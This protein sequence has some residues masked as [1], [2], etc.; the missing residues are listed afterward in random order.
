V[1]VPLGWLAEW[2]DL[3]PLE[4]F[5]ER[6]SLGALEIK[7][8]V[9]T[10]PDLSGLRVGLVCERRAHPDADRL[11]VCRVELGE[12]DPLEVVC[13][14]PNVAAGQ[15]VAL[16][17]HGATLP[18]GTR[19]KRSKI[20]GVVSAGMIC[21]A[22]ELGLGDDHAGIVVLPETAP[23]GAPLGAV[24][25]AGETILDVELI[26]NRGDCVSI[27]GLAREARALFGGDL[28]WPP[29]EPEE[30]SRAAAEDVR[31]AIDDAAG[32]PRYVARVVRDLRVGPSP[33]WLAG[34]LEAAGLRPVNNVVDVTNFVMLELG[35]P[36]HAFDL[37]K[38]HGGVIRV[39]AAADGEKLRTLDGALRALEPHDLV[40]ADASGAVAVAGVMGGAESEVDGGTRHV[41]LESAHF[42]PV[43]VRR[44]ARRLG[45]H[46]DAS[47]RFE[48]GV[49]PQG[50]RRAADRA[51]RL[52]GELAGGVV[53]RGAVEA[54]GDAAPP[55]APIALE[56]A[57]VNR[58]LGTHLT[59]DAVAALLA[60]LEIEVAPAGPGAFTCTP[61][62][63]RSDLAIPADLVEEV[64]RLHGYDRIPADLPTGPFEGASEPPERA[65]G[66]AL[67]SA[68]A[69]A[70]LVEVMTFPGVPPGDADA[71]GLAPGDPRR[72]ALAIENPV[73]AGDAVLRTSLVPSLLRVAAANLSRQVERVRIFEVGR[74]FLAREPGALPEERLAGAGLLC[75]AGGVGLWEPRDVPLFHRAKG[76]AERLLRALGREAAFQPDAGEP[77]LHPGASG[78]FRIGGHPV[79]AVGELHPDAA[80]RFGLGV[81]CALVVVDGSAL[82]A[83]PARVPRYREP[84]RHPRVRRDL[85]LLLDHRARA[86]D[87]LAAIRE[88]AGATLVAAE[89]FDR[90][91]GAGVPE[92]KVSL[93]FRLLFQHAERTLTDAEVARTMERVV[94][95][96]EERFGAELR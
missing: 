37:E 29:L 67:R 24:L 2:V 61:P 22:R 30:G 89:V 40:I 43:R 57:R 21:S 59:A 32:C 84:S 91:E 94:R 25:A 62:V 20:R 74:V 47:Y 66:Q 11:S 16:A 80:A 52:L 87:V 93:A 54:L 53:S 50:Q 23:V 18:D 85:A 83:A 51:A 26:P 68:L 4:A 71:L 8:V 64:A 82:L 75:E 65:L 41:L 48:R 6:F 7:E 33:A 1:K 34:R 73:Q 31:V 72:C 81:P 90:Y 10:G 27:L 60:R 9:H 46:S 42:D 86:G 12:G 56:V 88:R 58:L 96:L 76:V 38:L 45:L 95:L 79:V 28:R 44:T 63:Y 78:E 5:E 35:Q 3:P 19:V 39:R 69:Q 14:A 49:D 55:P 15:K 17:P 70:G 77:Y 36:L 13:G 92:G